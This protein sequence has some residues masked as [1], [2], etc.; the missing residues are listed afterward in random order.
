MIL[1]IKKKIKR[2]EMQLIFKEKRLKIMYSKELNKEI[3]SFN[4]F[5]IY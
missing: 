5:K 3:I 1:A 4:K 2:L